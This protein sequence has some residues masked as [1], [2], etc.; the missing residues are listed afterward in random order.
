MGI[1]AHQ[2]KDIFDPFTQAGEATH[3]LHSG[4]GLGLAIAKQLVELQGGQISVQSTPGKGSEFEFTLPVHMAEGPAAAPQQTSAPTHEHLRILLVEDNQFNQLLATEVLHKLVRQPQIRIA[5]NGQE[6]VDAVSE[7]V[8]D[9]IFMDVKMP[10][11]DGFTATRHIRS[12][13]IQ[14]PTIALTANA[15]VEEGEKCLMSGM[16][17]YLSKPL[18]IYLLEEKINAWA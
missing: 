9:L 15:T 2:L 12:K 6:A 1:P 14:T 10:V 4:T 7:A 3:L 5:V 8:F 16:N 18:S 17:D 11:M 13:G